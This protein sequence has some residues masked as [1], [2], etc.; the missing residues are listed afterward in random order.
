[1]SDHSGATTVIPTP[2]NFEPTLSDQEFMKI[3]HLS[4]K[5]SHL[6]HIIGNCLK[7]ILR[8]SDDE[9]RV[10]VFPLSLEQRM[11]RIGELAEIGSISERSQRLFYELR[12]LLKGIQYVRNNVIHAIVEL[13]EDG[14]TF[15][16]RSK[17]RSLTKEQVFSID[18]ITNYTAHVVMALRFSLG[19]KDGSVLDYTLPDRPEIP[20]FLRSLVQFPQG[21]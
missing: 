13:G 1:V 9:A 12:A 16:L 10:I 3:G 17:N 4:I 2:F 6:E 20:E 7:V 15:H 8:L 5:W 21:Q 11:T 14:H 18:D 19:F